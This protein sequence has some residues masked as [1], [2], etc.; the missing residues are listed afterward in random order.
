[1]S[2]TK[3]T[4]L[5]DDVLLD[6]LAQLDPQDLPNLIATNT[7][8]YALYQTYKS[9]IWN[10]FTRRDF[11]VSGSSPQAYV[12]AVR[13]FFS[14]LR[15]EDSD[16]PNRESRQAKMLGQ[17]VRLPLSVLT[18]I[19]DRNWAHI[20]G[21][22]VRLRP[23]LLSEIVRIIP[24]RF[25]KAFDVLDTE[26]TYVCL[27]HLSALDTEHKRRVALLWRQWQPRACTAILGLSTRQQQSVRPQQYAHKQPVFL[28]PATESSHTYIFWKQH[29]PL[30]N[31]AT[32]S[33]PIP[34]CI[35]ICDDRTITSY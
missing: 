25:Y 14:Q 34:T 21:Q 31:T 22:C 32:K 27:S 7:A 33:P 8:V 16:D 23:E 2:T 11:G 18:T 35:R 17:L 3:L 13:R 4:S 12:T 9:A 1:M 26:Y 5:N 6:V 20:L 24:E 19:R 15:S 30:F 29:T 10:T 28:P